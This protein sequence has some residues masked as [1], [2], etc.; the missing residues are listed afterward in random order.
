MPVV[1]AYYAA[2]TGLVCVALSARVIGQRIG[3]HVSIGV[4]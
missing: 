4:G 2:L 3:E 1:S